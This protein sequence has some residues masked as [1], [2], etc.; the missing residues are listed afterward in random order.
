[1]LSCGPDRRYQRYD[2]EMCAGRIYW[3]EELAWNSEHIGLSVEQQNLNM[4]SKEI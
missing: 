2:G 3:A 4:K 1:M